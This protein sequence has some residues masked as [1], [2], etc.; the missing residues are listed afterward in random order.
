[1]DYA[2]RVYEYIDFRGAI[3]RRELGRQLSDIPRTEMDGILDRGV[4]NGAL[5]L[6]RRH[7]NPNGGR[8]STVYSLCRQADESA[9]SDWH[10]R[11]THAWAVVAGIGAGVALAVIRRARPPI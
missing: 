5:T 1:V 11:P 7:L 10:W 9:T 2:D 8:P 4:Q 6:E 3:T